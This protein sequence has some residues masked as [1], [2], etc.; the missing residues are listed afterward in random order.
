[1]LNRFAGAA[2]EMRE[3]LLVNPYDVGALAE[4]LYRAIT[5]PAE[6]R[7]Q[8]LG[9]LRRR[10]LRHTIQDWMDEILAEVARLRGRA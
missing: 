1:V 4:T 10:V 5:L 3:A 6:E 9:A 2:R 8:R 7:E